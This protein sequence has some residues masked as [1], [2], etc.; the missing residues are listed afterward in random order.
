LI[1]WP[2]AVGADQARQIA[3]AGAGIKQRRIQGATYSNNSRVVGAINMTDD[4]FTC[5]D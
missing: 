2:T 1:K 5:V 4:S 3:G